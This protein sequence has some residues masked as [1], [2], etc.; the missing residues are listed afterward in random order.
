MKLKMTLKIFLKK[1]Y[2]N[3]AVQLTPLGIKNLKYYKMISS[4]SKLLPCKRNSKKA[5]TP[6]Q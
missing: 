6:I 4:I 5:R 3:L 1:K 2:K